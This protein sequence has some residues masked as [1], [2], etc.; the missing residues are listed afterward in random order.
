MS[1]DDREIGVSPPDLDFGY[2]DIGN[3]N[4][5]ILIVSFCCGRILY[6]KKA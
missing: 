6:G 2:I 3:A 4:V 1:V 5:L